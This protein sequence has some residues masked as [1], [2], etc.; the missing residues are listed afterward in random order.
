MHEHLKKIKY[1]NTH[2]PNSNKERPFSHKM[3]TKL[4]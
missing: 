4:N 2:T 3:L 1:N